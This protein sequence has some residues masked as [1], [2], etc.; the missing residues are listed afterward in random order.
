MDV[1]QFLSDNK[2]THSIA[3]HTIGL[4]GFLTCLL[5]LRVALGIVKEMRACCFT[6]S[7]LHSCGVGFFFLSQS[8]NILWWFGFH[9]YVVTELQKL[10]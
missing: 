3:Q 2:H 6:L 8:L 7:D 5:C 9:M 1:V 4:S 10:S